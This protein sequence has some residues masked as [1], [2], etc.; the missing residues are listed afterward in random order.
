[1]TSPQD[2]EDKTDL[3][4]TYSTDTF[5]S[6]A[7][8]G[9]AN[10]APEY[11]KRHD[12][13]ELRFLSSVDITKGKIK[14]DITR[15][16]RLQARDYSTDKLEYKEYL[17]WESNWYAKNWLENELKVLEHME[18]KYLQQT[19][20]VTISPPDLKTGKMV[21]EYEQGQ[22]R[23]V[24]TIP[25]SKETVDKLLQGAHPL[26]PDSINITDPSKVI[27]YGKID[28]VLGVQSFRCAD[29]DYNQFVTPKWDDFVKLAIQPGGPAK[30]TPWW[31]GE[32]EE[33]IKK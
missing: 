13:H 31:M 7:K 10:K 25:F 15:M 21:K 2:Q 14:I 20:K 23:E 3:K 17:M 18:G 28:H 6:Y 1:M 32:P 8:E 5:D 26:G 19:K 29:Y 9:F 22:P 33:F 24:Y 27:F 12:R 11:H 16:F 4:F 30:R